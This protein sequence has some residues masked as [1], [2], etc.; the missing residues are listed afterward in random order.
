VLLAWPDESAETNRFAVVIPHAAS[1]VLTHSWGGLFPGQKSLPPPAIAPR[2][3]ASSPPAAA[4][5][6]LCR[7]GRAHRLA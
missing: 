4:L 2:W 1:L 6:R 7:S 5:S 3:L